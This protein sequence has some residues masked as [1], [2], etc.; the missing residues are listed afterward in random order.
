MS[1][2]TIQKVSRR[3]ALAP[4]AYLPLALVLL[5]PLLVE[6]LGNGLP[7]WGV[8]WLLAVS[9]YASLKWLTFVDY[10][11]THEA[12]MSR[13]L[14]Y[15]FLWPGMNAGAFFGEHPPRVASFDEML[16]VGLKI[17]FGVALFFGAAPALVSVSPFFAAWAA[18]TGLYFLLHSGSFHAL[19]LYWQAEGRHAEL[20]MH[21]P[22]LSATVG[23]YWGRRW[24]TAFRDLAQRYVFRPLVRTQG[25]ARATMAVF[26]ASGII[27]DLAISVPARGGWGLPTLFF[28]LQGCG[29]LFERSALGKRIGLGHGWRGRVFAWIVV[30]GPAPLLFHRPFLYQVIL[31]MVEA[32]R[33]SV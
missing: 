21:W 18:L 9:V 10:V 8:M 23:D 7:D 1:S 22:V 3:A 20:L 16:F 19:A 4:M 27:H 2:S 33:T 15:L 13:S 24:N 29:V 31:P 30:L 11:T 28:L 26:L 5:F 12:S 14:G 32:L 6:V 17:A 25:S